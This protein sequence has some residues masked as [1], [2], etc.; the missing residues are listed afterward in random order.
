MKAQFIEVGHLRVHDTRDIVISKVVERG[1]TAGIHIN[2]YIKRPRYTGFSKGG[3]FIPLPN[4]AELQE[5]VNKV[6]NAL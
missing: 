3:V 5:I 6:V 4:C 1:D 2:S